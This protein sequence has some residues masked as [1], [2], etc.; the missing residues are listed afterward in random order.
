MKTRNVDLENTPLL[1]NNICKYIYLE[2]P[3]L[4]ELKKKVKEYE[5]VLVRAIT[6]TYK[7]LNL[8]LEKNGDYSILP[9]GN[10]QSS[11]FLHF[12]G[13][14]KEENT[15]P[16]KTLQYIKYLTGMESR[17][18]DASARKII[19]KKQKKDY[20]RS[21]IVPIEINPEELE[22]E[23]V[24]RKQGQILE[25][26]ITDTNL[27]KVSFCRVNKKHDPNT[28]TTT[29]SLK[30]E[31]DYREILEI[32]RGYSDPGEQGNNR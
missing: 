19:T 11:I 27:I 16:E 3:S 8:S 4:P 7:I 2:A 15:N 21:I 17:K 10:Y 26:L 23:V 14:K 5:I 32:S 30:V 28:N 20:H 13:K 22:I 9:D 12:S 31:Y 6:N 1:T 25:K 29:I 24:S 18:A